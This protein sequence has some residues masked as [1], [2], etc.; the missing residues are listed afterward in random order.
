MPCKLS[1]SSSSS[2][3][4][5]NA[6]SA[7][8]MGVRGS[9]DPEVMEVIDDAPDDGFNILIK[10]QYATYF[11]DPPVQL[12]VQS[13][14]PIKT[15]LSKSGHCSPPVQHIHRDRQTGMEFKVERIIIPG[16]RVWNFNAF[17]IKEKRSGGM[18]KLVTN[19][20]TNWHQSRVIGNHWWDELSTFIITAH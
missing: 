20:I 16:N 7:W 13:R 11:I 17:L 5:M 6:N 9:S 19:A 14:S 15:I 18:S 2:L 1:C 8:M 3:S 10:V 12:S 4:V